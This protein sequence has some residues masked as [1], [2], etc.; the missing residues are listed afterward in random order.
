MS[1]YEITHARGA[2]EHMNPEPG[3]LWLQRVAETWRH[4]VWLN[5]TAERHWGY[6]PSI[7]M[8]RGIMEGRMYPLTLEGLDGAMGELMR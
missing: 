6:T 1:P 7:A 2:V 5:P 3:A 8:I 4:C